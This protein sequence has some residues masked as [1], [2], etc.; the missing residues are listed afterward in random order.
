MVQNLTS[1]CKS[2]NAI[3]RWPVLAYL[4]VFIGIT[5]PSWAAESQP[6]LQEEGFNP[7]T[8]VLLEGNIVPLDWFTPE[9]K[10][11]NLVPSLKPIN[12]QKQEKSAST[13]S[14]KISPGKTSAC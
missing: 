5:S 11:E 14:C 3:S 6:N 7:T 10:P 8:Y 1:N 2:Y 4:I 13:A 12:S 9:Q